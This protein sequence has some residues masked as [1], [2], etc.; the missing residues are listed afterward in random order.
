MIEA[1]AGATARVE[2]A[3]VSCTLDASMVTVCVH[4]RFVIPY[5]AFYLEGIGRVFGFDSITFD[6][7]AMPDETEFNDGFAFTLSEPGGTERARRFYISSNDFARYDS[8]ALEW[9]DRYG[10]VN[11]DP[12]ACRASSSPEKIVPIGPS[13]GVRGWGSLGRTVHDIGRIW[14]AGGLAPRDALS[15]LRSTGKLVSQRLPEQSYVPGRAQDGYVFFVS[16]PWKKHPEVN[17]PRARFIRACKSATRVTFEG[18]FAPRRRRDVAGIDDILAERTY[19]FRQW[20]RNTQASSV[21]F[22]CPAVHQCLGWK[23]GEFLALGKAIISLPLPRSMPAPLQHGEHVHYVADDENA[24]RFAI[25]RIVQDAVY[26]TRLEVGAR[27]Y[28]LEH[29]APERVIERLIFS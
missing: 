3:P 21:V 26:R 10:M 11:H 27:R 25:E 19:P 17:P 18:G 9:C 12:D 20:L 14:R 1:G 23:L 7:D 6:R 2:T 28:Y 22:N 13:F 24:M 15:V 29:L 4:P 5:Y 16:W 8:V